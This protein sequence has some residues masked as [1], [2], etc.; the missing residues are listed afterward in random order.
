MGF[1]LLSLSQLLSSILFLFHFQT[2]ISSSN[3]SSPSHSCAH[4]QSLSLLQFKASFSINSSASGYCQH[5]KTESWKEGTDCCL[6]DGVTCEMKTGVVTELNL[7]CSLLYG[8]LHPNSTL[9]SLRHLRKLDLSDNHFKSSHIFPQFGQFSNLTHLN[10]SLSVF[11]GQVPSEFSLLSKLVSLDLSKNDNPS[12]EPISFDKLVQN[13]TQLRELRLSRVDMSL[14]APDS[15]MNLSSSLSSLILNSC[16]LQGKLPSSMRKFKHLQYLNLGKNSFSGPIPYD[17][18]QLTE[19]ALLVLSGN[20]ND[21][22]SLE[23][24]SFDKLVQ[25]L[26]QLRDLRLSMVDMSMVAPDS[27][28]NLSSSLSSLILYS[29]RLQGKFPSSMRK[30]KHL[31]CFNLG[32]NN[33]T[34]SIPY[35]FG[36]LN[37]LVSIDLS[38]NDY[39]SV[40]PNSFDKIVQNLTKLRGLNLGSVNMVIPNS[41]ANLSSS[42]SAL[43]LWSCGLQ[44]K[45]PGNIFLLPNL[46]VLDV[47]SNDCLTGS[48][49][50]SN[51]SNY[52]WFLGLSH[53]R[54]SVDLGN[55]FFTN[56]KSLET[57]A[58]RD[59]NILRSN[60]TL[61]GHLTQL[62][63]LELVGNNLGG[64]IPSSLGNLVQLHSLFLDRNNFSGQIPS[65]LRNLVQLHSLFL[66]HNNFSGQIPDFLSTLTQLESLGLS[67][68]HLVGSIP[69]Q[70]NTLSLK[71]FDLRNN[72]LHGPIPSS[73]FKQ[74]NLETLALAS[75]SK[76][77]AFSKG[78][79]LGY[80]NLNGNELEGKIPSSIINCA[81]LEVLDLGNN[82]IEDTFPYFLEMLPELHVLV[83]KSNKLQGFVNSPTTN[84]SFPKLRIFDI[85]SNNLSGPLPTEYLYSLEALMAYDKKSTYMMAKNYSDY[86]YSIKVTWKGFEIKFEKFQ[87]ALGILDFSNN[88]FTGE[89][90]NL[91]GKLNGLRQLNLSHNSLR[92]QIPLS[93]GMLFNLESLD[94]SSNLL[95]GRIP[96]QLAFITFLAVLNLSHNQLEG[97]IP[98]G[99]QFQ[100]FSASSF[101]GNLGLCG[102]PMPKDCNSSEAPALQPSNF[103]DGDDSTFFAD[104]FGWKAVAIG[105]GCG[106]VFGVTV[107][108]VVYRARKPAWFLR[109]VE[110]IWNL[111]ARRT[112]KNARR[113]GVRRN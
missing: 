16:G 46:Q 87:S 59:C 81:M 49:P 89:I 92:G 19:L 47:T 56:L 34:G 54:I 72:H 50:S 104:G 65:S 70:I 69:S 17:L 64:L 11:A 90:P 44:G 48:F 42:L 112:K 96:Q 37:E 60:L 40:E 14:V 109:L 108:Y 41:L 33:L 2:A 25:N 3:Y 63:R 105:Y 79:N 74:E 75:N 53:T 21:Y 83:L 84:D 10:L 1:Y 30:L 100:T 107:G 102:F 95:T 88:N 52:L 66:D 99:K 31:Q 94:L 43:S 20:E 68:N 29:C 9:F 51:V 85:S 76:L 23:P 110:D 78:N 113:N 32:E 55:D 35:D 86:A 58:M 45:F 111:K 26:T 93:L 12:L 8:T 28:M 13:L 5:L 98:R 57:L 82:K 6:W 7:A 22:L 80:L 27:L 91:T 77:T 97:A 39:L 101:E 103:H 61:V 106:F 15:L 71:L 73:I 62:T 18:E 67:N 36:Q 24:T 4:D 38:F